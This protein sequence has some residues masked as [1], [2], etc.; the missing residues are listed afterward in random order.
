VP[1]VIYGHGG[2]E[3]LQL[4]AHDLDMVLDHS[5]G[6]HFLVSLNVEGEKTARRA[7]LQDVQHHPVSGE[8]LHVDFLRVV[9]DEEI[10][11]TVPVEAVGEASGVKTQ[12]GLLEQSMH[13]IEIQ[14]LPKDL[15]D[16]IR[17]DVTDLKVGDSI[18]VGNLKLPP[19]VK[20]VEDPELPVFVV[21]EPNVAVVQT[22]EEAKAVTEALKEKSVRTTAE[23]SKA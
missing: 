15:P 6:Q 4:S 2:P 14:C 13:E 20:A 16:L 18:T 19:G 7:I 21:A 3:N 11:S 12:G 8:V 10:T 1:A 9:M 5:V 17:V 23:G 22:A